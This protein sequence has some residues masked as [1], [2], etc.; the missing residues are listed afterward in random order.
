M[1]T[2]DLV[3]LPVG[4]EQEWQDMEHFDPYHTASLVPFRDNGGT[5][6]IMMQQSGDMDRGDD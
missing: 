1:C 6:K 2:T 4:A 5:G 3:E